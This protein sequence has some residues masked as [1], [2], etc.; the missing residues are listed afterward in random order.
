MLGEAGLEP[1]SSRAAA[2]PL[3]PALT[4]AHPCLETGADAGSGCSWREQ[5]DAA[6]L[7]LF[8]SG[9]P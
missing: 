6:V 8:Q 9:S 3:C 1:R 4:V 2:L 5:E 7:G